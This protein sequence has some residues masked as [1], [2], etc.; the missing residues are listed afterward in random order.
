MRGSRRGCSCS[1]LMSAPNGGALN[2]SRSFQL[3]RWRQI[4]RRA[5]YLALGLGLNA[6]TSTG[7]EGYRHQVHL[8]IRVSSSN[9]GR[10]SSMITRRLG[11][12]PEGRWA[13]PSTRSN[14]TLDICSGP[15]A[16]KWGGRST[17]RTTDP[18]GGSGKASRAHSLSALSP[19]LLNQCPLEKGTR[20]ALM[21]SSARKEP[22][23]SITQP[24]RLHLSL[25][26]TN[27]I[28]FHL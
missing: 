27:R 25:P 19:S 3:V 10:S 14:T 13:Y 9:A 5:P 4:L 20:K 24:S 17:S 15:T 6:S 16:S 28:Y 1:R 23:I 22:S 26:G 2:G 21:N 7:G 11:R 12:S 8:G 18:G